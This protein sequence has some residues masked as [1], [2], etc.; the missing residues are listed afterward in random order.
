MFALDEIGQPPSSC[1][2]TASPSTPS[3]AG[4]G[5]LVT[6]SIFGWKD[7]IITGIW[8]AKLVRLHSHMRSE[9]GDDDTSAQIQALETKLATWE[10]LERRVQ[11][12]IEAAPSVITLDVGGTLFKTSKAT[13]LNVEDSY[14]HAMLGSGLWYPDGPN[15]TYFLD[16]DPITFHHVMAYLRTGTFI[17]D[18][19]SEWEKMQ[20]QYSLDYLNISIPTAE[21]IEDKHVEWTWDPNAISPGMN[22]LQDNFV[23][24]APG[25]YRWMTAKGNVANPTLF[26]VRVDSLSTDTYIGLA[27]A[28]TPQTAGYFLRLKNGQLRG[29]RGN[30]SGQYHADGVKSGDVLTVRYKD[31]K[32][33]FLKNDQDLGVAF[34][35]ESPNETFFPS[36]MTF[37]AAKVTILPPP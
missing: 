26:R 34:T 21:P 27:P 23:V 12:N 6:R 14:F 37:A 25:Y 3:S 29:P 9:D 22:L 36:V 17:A 13:L 33:A 35:V 8:S 4:D 11:E 16:L 7:E 31:S 5:F 30:I 1:S 18:D 15:N 32:I 28:N 2:R 10:A 19:L 20:L 24:Q